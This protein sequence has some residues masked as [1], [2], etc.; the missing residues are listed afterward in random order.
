MIGQQKAVKTNLATF[1][2]ASAPQSGMSAA[3]A[4]P[5]ALSLPRQVPLARCPA[6][7][8]AVDKQEMKKRGLKDKQTL[9][10]YREANRWTQGTNV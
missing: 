1:E 2:F 8:A 6:T 10:F 3:L 5:Q 7:A 9:Y 4:I